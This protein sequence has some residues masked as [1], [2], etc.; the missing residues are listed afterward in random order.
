MYEP[1]L[2]EQVLRA[3]TNTQQMIKDMRARSQGA[4]NVLATTS[5]HV[6][7]HET[8]E[9]VSAPQV[10]TDAATASSVVQKDTGV[11][12]DVLSHNLLVQKAK[13]GQLTPEEQQALAKRLQVVTGKYSKEVPRMADERRALQAT[14][15]SMEKDFLK[16]IKQLKQQIEAQHGSLKDTPPVINRKALEEYG[17]EFGEMADEMQTLRSEVVTIKKDVQEKDRIQ[18]EAQAQKTYLDHVNTLIAKQYDGV[19]AHVLNQDSHFMRFLS[20]PINIAGADCTRNELLG[21]AYRKNDAESGASY[22]IE[23]IESLAPPS[24]TPPVAVETTSPPEAIPTIPNIQAPIGGQE[25]GES[26]MS[27]SGKIWTASE[28]GKF[29]KDSALGKYSD[30]D[31]RRLNQDIRVAVQDGRIVEDRVPSSQPPPNSNFVDGYKAH[32]NVNV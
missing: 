16:E 18:K 9:G 5:A 1:N 15:F 31:F 17:S 3:E 2:P 27:Q 10:N 29:Y 30:A 19:D 23:Y 20:Q 11:D 13:S 7:T 24:V 22:F 6:E 32:F 12:K 21:Y 26:T 25:Y 4:E 8:T 14:M 28:V